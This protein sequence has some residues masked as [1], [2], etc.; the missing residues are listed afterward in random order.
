MSEPRLSVS[1]ITKILENCTVPFPHFEDNLFK[2]IETS[3]IK[4]SSSNK[5]NLHLKAYLI[6]VPTF[7]SI[8]LRNKQPQK[9]IWNTPK[10]QMWHNS[11]TS[12]NGRLLTKLLSIIS[13]NDNNK[14]T[15]LDFEKADTEC[16]NIKDFA[17]I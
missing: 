10:W 7:H 6:I 1:W 13:T 3:K 9:K 16:D 15:A 5:V 4:Q 11:N 17:G 14:V 2:K 12:T 8:D